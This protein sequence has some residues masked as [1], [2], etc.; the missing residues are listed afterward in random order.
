MPDT[1]IAKIEAKIREQLTSQKV[2]FLLGAGSSYLSG[3]GYP[4][5]GQL[6]GKISADLPQ[7]ERNE[8]QAKL[9][10]GAVGIEQALDLLDT[11][12]VEET[13]HRHLVV[14]AI[15]NHFKSIQ[16]PLDVHRAFLSIISNRRDQVVKIFSLNYDPLIERAAELE[17][18]R[19][20]DGFNGHEQAFFDG[21][22]FRHQLCVYERSWKGAHARPINGALKLIKLHGSLGWFEEGGIGIRRSRFDIDISG[23]TK[24]LMIPPQYRKA[25]DTGKL[26]YSTLW[27]EFRSSLLHSPELIHRLV[28]LGYGMKDEHVNAEFEN[29]LANRNFT[30]ICIAKELDDDAFNRWS[31]KQNVIIV[32]EKRC[33]LKKEIGVGHPEWWAFEKIVEELRKW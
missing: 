21:E 22:S 30:L 27:A 2:G 26:P 17:K 14:K 9:D 8:I 33:A 25:Q 12:N 16:V 10:N 1:F 20:C 6:W 31:Q 24:R 11:G 5:A 7:K 4:L 15:A 3:H 29:A 32:T 28:V 13:T 19:I 23:T 18:I